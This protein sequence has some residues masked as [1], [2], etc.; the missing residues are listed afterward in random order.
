MTVQF[1]E[2]NKH[3]TLDEDHRFSKWFRAREH[4]EEWV[5]HFR[6]KKIPC[7]LGRKPGGYVALFIAKECK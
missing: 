3:V 5:E 1:L 4:L 7:A 6:G 2:G